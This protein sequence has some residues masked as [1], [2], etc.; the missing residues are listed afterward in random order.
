VLLRQAPGHS[1]TLPTT[2]TLTLVFKYTSRRQNFVFFFNW[3][4]FRYQACSR[5]WKNG[6]RNEIWENGN[7]HVQEFWILLRQTVNT[8]V[9]KHH[10]GLFLL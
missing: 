3:K 8:T 4:T 1:H 6:N 5:P 10:I 9:M 7:G 2:E